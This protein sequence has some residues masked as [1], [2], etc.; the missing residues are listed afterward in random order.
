M[1]FMVTLFYCFSI[2]MATAQFREVDLGVLVLLP[3]KKKK[4]MLAATVPV[5]GLEN[6]LLAER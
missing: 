5:A 1:I 4:Y 6:S 3:C 2:S